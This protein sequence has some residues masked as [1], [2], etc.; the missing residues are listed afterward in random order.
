M[1]F[2]L[3]TFPPE[4]LNYDKGPLVIRVITSLVVLATVVTI[5]RL[6]IQL[7]RRGGIEFDDWLIVAAL[8]FLWGEY[9]DGY[10]SVK[11]GGIGLH[12]PVALATKKDALRNVFIV[13]KCIPSLQR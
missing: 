11:R 2:D 13:S 4:Y 3:S 9:A 8:G 6:I 12:L 1:S 5:L 10:L 7:Q